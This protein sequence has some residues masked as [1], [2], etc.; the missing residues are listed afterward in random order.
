MSVCF[1]QRTVREPVARP[2]GGPLY[3]PLERLQVERPVDR[4]SYIKDRCRRKLVLDLGAMDETAHTVKRGHGTWLHD[5]IASVAT[6]VIGLDSSDLV[7][8]DGLRTADNATIFRGNILQLGPWLEKIDFTP[9]IIVAGELVE[10]LDN[11]L[12]FLKSLEATQRL[13]GKELILT[14]P[15]A[16][17]LHNCIIAMGSRESTHHD[18]L[19]ILSYKTLWTLC[20]RSGFKS[21]TIR[22][23]LSRFSEMKARN[24][25]IRL[26]LI[27][28]A[29]R[30]INLLE[31]IFPM[32]G[33]GYVVHAE[34]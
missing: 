9:D 4:I 5:E 34:I 27:A 24:R 19:C 14:T 3:T 2:V 12:S 17:A 21:W 33:F 7:P 18:H 23:Y 32:Y 22:P 20:L 30:G 6:K 13:K 11:P 29:E 16:T 28:T 26:G 10:H 25:G 8:T 15:N 31:W 1:G